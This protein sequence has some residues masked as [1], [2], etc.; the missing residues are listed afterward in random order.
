V[1]EVQVEVVEVDQLLRLKLGDVVEQGRVVFAQQGLL[2]P[3]LTP[4][5]DSKECLEGM[6]A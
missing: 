4:P 6:F 1:E 5:S 2:L 3:R